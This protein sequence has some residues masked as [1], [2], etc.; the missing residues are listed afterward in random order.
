MDFSDEKY[1]EAI[2]KNED[3]NNAYESIKKICNSLQEKTNCPETD[4]DDFL[5]FLAGKWKE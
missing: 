3:V 1:F 4:I 2:N 5:R